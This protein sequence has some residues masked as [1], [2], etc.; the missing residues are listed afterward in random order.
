MGPSAYVQSDYSVM[1]SASSQP[2]GQCLSLGEKWLDVDELSPPSAEVKN[3]WNCTAFPFC[4]HV[5]VLIKHRDKSLSFVFVY[6]S[7]VYKE[8]FSMSA[9]KTPN[10]DRF[11][12]TG[13]F[14][15]S[16]E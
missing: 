15:F 16:S 2:S 9:L 12:R 11:L 6:C 5:V 4:L 14:V 10:P 8:P 7:V 3:T 13:N 1:R